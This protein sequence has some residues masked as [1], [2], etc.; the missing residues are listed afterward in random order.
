[1][2][3]ELAHVSPSV[4]LWPMPLPLR[5]SLPAGSE[6]ERD[7]WLSFVVVFEF[8]DSQVWVYDIVL[9]SKPPLL[10][11]QS[12]RRGGPRVQA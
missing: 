11:F 4:S 6:R 10:G 5:W 7:L 2:S 1:M 3:T 12:A 8:A 9:K